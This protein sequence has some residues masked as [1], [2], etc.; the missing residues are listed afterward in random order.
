VFPCATPEEVRAS[1]PK[2]ADV[3]AF[4]CRNPI[5][6]AHYELFTRALHAPNVRSGAVCLV[7]P[8]CGPTQVRGLKRRRLLRGRGGRLL[9][10][11]GGRLLVFVKGAWLRNGPRLG[12]EC[13]GAG[14]CGSLACVG[15]VAAGR[16]EALPPR[17]AHD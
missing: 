16:L 14:L 17:S 12:W 11:R 3:V 8:T 1:L 5:H 9:R 4:Q 7:H 13:G 15:L 2:G 10:G 6:R